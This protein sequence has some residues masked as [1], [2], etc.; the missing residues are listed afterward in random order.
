MKTADNKMS[1]KP[2]TTSI[3]TLL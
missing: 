3:L 2:N 1:W